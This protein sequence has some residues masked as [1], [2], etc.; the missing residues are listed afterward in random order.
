MAGGAFFEPDNPLH[1]EQFWRQVKVKQLL[2]FLEGEGLISAKGHGHKTIVIQV[3]GVVMV[4]FVGVIVIMVMPMV[5]LVV[6]RV[7]VIVRHARHLRG[8]RANIK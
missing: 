2:K 1:A 3:V 5:M 6:V 4:V 8:A 7:C